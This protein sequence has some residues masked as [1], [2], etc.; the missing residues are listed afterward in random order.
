M[1]LIAFARD[2][3]PRYPLV[4]VANRDEFRDRET[5][6]THFWADAPGLLAGRDRRAGQQK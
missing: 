6:P 3:H 1:C 4:L 5:E 2:S